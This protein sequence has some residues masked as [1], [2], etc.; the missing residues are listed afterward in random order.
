[1]RKFLTLQGKSQDN[2]GG[3]RHSHACKIS[4]EDRKNIKRQDESALLKKFKVNEKV[5]RLILGRGQIFGEDE[6]LNNVYN[7]GKPKP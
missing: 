3:Q 4:I 6:L 2:T 1:M 5:K 7:H